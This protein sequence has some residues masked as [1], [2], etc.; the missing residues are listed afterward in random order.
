MGTTQ[1]HLTGTR[2]IRGI[3]SAFQDARRL[4]PRTK[5]RVELRRYTLNLRYW[6]PGVAAVNGGQIMDLDWSWIKTLPGKRIGE[7]RISNVIGGCDNLRVIFFDPDIDTE[8]LPMM[9]V[10]AVLQKKKNQFAPQQLRMFELRRLLVI[11]RF[12]NN[13]HH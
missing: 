3:K 2:L 6:P 11:E 1:T 7:L 8:P 5:D 12:Y 9:W 10:L 4:L 13:H